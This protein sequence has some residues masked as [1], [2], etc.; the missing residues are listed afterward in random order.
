[1]TW[2]V[3]AYSPLTI[4]SPL[5]AEHLTKFLSSN[6]RSTYLKQ[7]QWFTSVFNL[8]CLEQK[9]SKTFGGTT[10]LAVGGVGEGTL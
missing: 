4:D 5:C 10:E 9:I 1:M 3:F 7:D 2:S 8:C 6:T